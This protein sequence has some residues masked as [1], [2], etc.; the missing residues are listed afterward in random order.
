MNTTAL[1]L[2]KARIKTEDTRKQQLVIVLAVL[3]SLR[4]TDKSF[5]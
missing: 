1:C 4:L 3:N 5:Q 2:T